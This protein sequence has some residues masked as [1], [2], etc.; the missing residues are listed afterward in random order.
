MRKVSLIAAGIL[1]GCCVGCGP[2]ATDT[3]KV[4][5]PPTQ[6][7]TTEEIQKAVESGKIDPESY[8][9]Y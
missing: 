6:E 3:S 9:K 2:T 7:Q 4:P 5:P 8:G 1:A